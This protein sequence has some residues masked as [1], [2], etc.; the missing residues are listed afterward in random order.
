MFDDPIGDHIRLVETVAAAGVPAPPQWQALHD[1]LTAFL[2]LADQTP[3]RD[4]LTDAIVGGADA[5]T[6][7]LRALALA[8]VANQA[9]VE[10]VHNHVRYAVYQRMRETYDA[11]APDNY[12]AVSEL[13]NT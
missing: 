3:L 6:P 4:Q 2:A 1:R 10:K 9:Q 8:E 5:S 13:F 7:T 11:A 12:A